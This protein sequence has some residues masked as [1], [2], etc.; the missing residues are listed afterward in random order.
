[1][2]G[3]LLQ[4]WT[5]VFAGSA[6]E[7]AWSF[8]SSVDATPSPTGLLHTKGSHSSRL[9]NRTAWVVPGDELWHVADEKI[10]SPPEVR[11]LNVPA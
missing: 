2:R 8:Q 7:V 5:H 1:M 9:P 6:L 10:I 11:A 4:V 3:G